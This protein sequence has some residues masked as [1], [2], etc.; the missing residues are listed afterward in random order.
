MQLLVFVMLCQGSLI[1]ERN[2][3]TGCM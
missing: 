3:A 1:Q 2:L